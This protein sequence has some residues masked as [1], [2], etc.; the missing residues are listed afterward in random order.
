MQ[1]VVIRS[2][3]GKPAVRGAIGWANSTLYAKIQA[4]LFVPP[5]KIGP[6]SSRWPSDEVAAVQEAIIAG[7]DEDELRSLVAKLVAQRSTL[8]QAA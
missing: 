6:R 8:R 2:L 5:V 3:L 1:P 4:G 7:A